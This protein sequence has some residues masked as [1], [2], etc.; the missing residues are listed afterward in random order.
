MFGYDL[1]DLHADFTLDGQKVRV[2]MPRPPG[3]AACMWALLDDWSPL[4]PG[5]LPG[6]QAAYWAA[7][8]ADPEDGLTRAQL[9]PVAFRL[10]RQVYGVPWWSAHRILKEA[11]DSYLSYQVWCVK[12]SFQP[13]EEPAD[14]IVASCVAYLSGQWTEQAQA[15]SWSDRIFKNPPGVRG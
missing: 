8:L 12:K 6:E 10:A 11:A 4:L 5:A 7:R 13:G 3:P 14:R 9:R 15:Q 1:G 2:T